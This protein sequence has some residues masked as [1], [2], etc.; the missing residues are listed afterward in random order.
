MGVTL[1]SFQSAG[2]V[3]DSMDFV[4]MWLSGAATSSTNSFNTPGL[5]PSGPGAEFD[6]SSRIVFFTIEGLKLTPLH[7]D[8]VLKA[9]AFGT[10]LSSSC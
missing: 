2:T 9:L 10:V 1:A 3:P 8:L 7:Y 5:M 4:K 6:L